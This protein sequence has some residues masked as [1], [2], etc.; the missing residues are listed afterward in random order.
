MYSLS[1]VTLRILDDMWCKLTFP[2]EEEEE[3]GGGNFDD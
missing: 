2:V 1:S 3:G